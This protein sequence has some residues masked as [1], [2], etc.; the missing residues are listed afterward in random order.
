[1]TT[2]RLRFDQD[3]AV[4]V[5]DGSVLRANVFRPDADGRFPVVMA[6]GIYGKDV[7]FADAFKP[8]WDKLTSLYP[9][10]CSDGSSGRYLRWETVDPERWVP[11][12]Y[13]V[14]QIDARG[15]GKSPGYLDP[16]S[17]R[18]IQDYYDAIEWAA[19]EPWCDGSVGLIGVSYYAITQ[20]LVAALR[21]PHLKAIVPWEGACDHYRDWSRHGGMLSGFAAAWWP[22]QVLVNQHGNGA[23]PYRDRETVEHTT[24]DALDEALLAGNRCDYP[25][26]L[27]RHTLD[28]EWHRE[29]T[30][31]LSRIDVPVLSA[32]N[33]GGPGIHLRGNIEGWMRCGSKDKWL[34]MHTGTHYESFYLPEYVAMQ[35]RFFDRYLKGLA[36][37]WDDEPRVRLSIRRPKEPHART[38]PPREGQG[39]DRRDAAADARDRTSVFT[40]TESEFPIGRT[41][42]TRLYL[43]A[44]TRALTP[45]NA[46]V[47]A[48][49][50]YGS[51]SAGLTFETAPFEQETEITG[52]VTLRLWIASS[53]ADLDLFATLRAFDPEGAE[54]VFDGA[55]EPTPVARGW[56]RASHRTLDETRTMPHR[57]W[58]AHRAPQP[59][60]PELAYRVDVEIWPTSIVL[61]EGFRLALTVAG[62]DFEFADVPGRILHDDPRDRGG[63]PVEATHTLHTGG[64]RESYLLLPVIPA[65]PFP[66]PGT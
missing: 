16:Y 59:L 35:K 45:A 40:R 2:C 22:R 51:S 31:D 47:H 37:G 53:G 56:L 55:H 30:P 23:S 41:Q 29:R 24:G 57:V 15:S 63:A 11:D 1:V 66:P 64:P 39:I 27:L 42:Y 3:V 8:Q 62:R 44:R 32:G 18:E 13:A 33:W 25:A 6:Q 14:I 9:G 36:N 38:A 17:P 60:V 19:R 4:T 65:S 61:P 50:S 26:A 12:G 20:W 7:H 5:S 28:D 46:E 10:L 54:V 49:A 21:P 52:F 58:H 48:E 43:D 34:S